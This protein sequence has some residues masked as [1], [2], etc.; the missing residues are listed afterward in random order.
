MAPDVA[1]LIPLNFMMPSLTA[2]APV[3]V[4]LPVRI[5]VPASLL[6]RPGVP[7]LFNTPLNVLALVDVPPSSKLRADAPFVTVPVSTSVPPSL[8][9]LVPPPPE[10]MPIGPLIVLLPAELR[11]QP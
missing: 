9:I 8:R 4:L 11:M 7:P 3:W 10:V 2:V 5:Q 6:M 1:P